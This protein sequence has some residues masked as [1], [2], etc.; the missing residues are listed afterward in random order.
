MIMH[1]CNGG[2]LGGALCSL[3]TVVASPTCI[4]WLSSGYSTPIQALLLYE[5]K[6]LSFYTT[7]VAGLEFW[8]WMFHG[9]EISKFELNVSKMEWKYI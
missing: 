4:V 7:G 2:V 5:I 3:A 9:D 6:H 8:Q 1:M